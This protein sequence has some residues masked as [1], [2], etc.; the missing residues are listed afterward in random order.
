MKSVTAQRE[1]PISLCDSWGQ[2]N[3]NAQE[4]DAISTLDDEIIM[5]GMMNYQ[6]NNCVCT[7]KGAFCFIVCC[8]HNDCIL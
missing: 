5:T 6:S 3:G 2:K 4:C 8:E 7:A 1:Q